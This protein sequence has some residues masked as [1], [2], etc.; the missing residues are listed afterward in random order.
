MKKLK[1]SDIHK[2]EKQYSYDNLYIPAYWRLPTIEELKKLKLDK[3]K[4]E[5]GYMTSELTTDQKYIYYVGFDFSTGKKEV[6]HTYTSMPM[7][8]IYIKE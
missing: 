7:N 8:V 3:D 1:K 4:C 2:V 5:F 6:R